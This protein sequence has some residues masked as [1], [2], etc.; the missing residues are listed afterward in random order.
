[1]R[2]EEFRVET[3]VEVSDLSAWVWTW[4]SIW[5]A[6]AG[7]FREAYVEAEAELLEE[8]VNVARNHFEVIDALNGEVAAAEFRLTAERSAMM[9]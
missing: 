1:L 2:E 4:I 5:R 9:S 6:S 7:G 3:S 8:V